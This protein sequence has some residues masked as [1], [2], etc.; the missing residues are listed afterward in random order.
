MEA[1]VLPGSG[2]ERVIGLDPAPTLGCA[3]AATLIRWLETSVQPLARGNMAADLVSLRVGGGHECRNRNRGSGGKRSEHATGKALDIFGFTLGGAGGASTSVSVEK[4]SGM[5]QKRFLEAVRASACGYFSTVLG[6][7]SDAFHSD[8][9]HLDTQD[10]RSASSRYCGRARRSGRQTRGRGNRRGAKTNRKTSGSKSRRLR[11]RGRPARGELFQRCIQ[12]HA[13][14]QQIFQVPE[15]RGRSLPG[16]PSPD[17][18][19]RH[20]ALPSDND[21]LTS[22]TMSGSMGRN[23]GA[24]AALWFTISGQRRTT[25]VSGS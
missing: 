1:I 3:T 25:A 19:V 20:E 23:Y 24:I 22:V 18:R 13:G 6:P 10:R 5:E 12:G 21:M 9:I 14:Y 16:G 4:P 11:P 7:G 8:H 15:R 17:H 2:A